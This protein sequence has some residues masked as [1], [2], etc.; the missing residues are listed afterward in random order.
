MITGRRRFA[1]FL[2]SL[3]H[4]YA[5]HAE[6]GFRIQFF[7]KD[8]SLYFLATGSVIMESHGVLRNDND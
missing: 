2:F 4:T 3:P 6:S 7:Q 8:H 1:L 5:F